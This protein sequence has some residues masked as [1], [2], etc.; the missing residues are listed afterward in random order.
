MAMW[1]DTSET[2]RNT[3]ESCIAVSLDTRIP[4]MVVDTGSNQKLPQGERSP[5]E[6]N[7][8]ENQLFTLIS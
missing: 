5:S 8:P 3:A 6:A 2:A 7:N 1:P 4:L